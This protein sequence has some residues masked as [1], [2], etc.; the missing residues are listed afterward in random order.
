M[1][2][3]EI[4]SDNELMCN[5]HLITYGT[6]ADED[7]SCYIR[8]EIEEMWNEPAASIR[9]KGREYSLVFKITVQHNPELTPEEVLMNY[10][11]QNNYFRIENYAHGNISFVDAIG[12][13]TGYFLKDN[14]YSGSTTA[15][16]EFG[17]TLGLS[18]PF[19]LDIRGSG[20]PGIMYPRGTLV[21][22][23]YQYDPKTPAGQKGGTMHPMYRK[24]RAEDIALLK[25]DSLVN[26]ENTYIIGAFSSVWHDAHKPS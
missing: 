19:N 25:I 1:G 2:T 16:H 18:H 5:A 15:A 9:F 3:I 17:H 23:I 11:P 24:V 21:D 8:K 26:D 22:P 12:C 6:A 10:Q 13:N 20:Q 4:I 14:L 7:V